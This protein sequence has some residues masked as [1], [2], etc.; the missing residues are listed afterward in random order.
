[1][2]I[3]VLTSTYSRWEGD[4]EPRFVDNLC[5]H[6]GAEHE[7]QVLAPHAPGARLHEV[8]D[9]IPVHRFRYAP[10]SLQTLAY[11]GGILPNLREQPLRF[12]LVPLFIAAQTRAILR[13]ARAHQFDVIHAHWIIPQGF[14]AALARLAGLRVPVVLTSHG[15][16][17][18]AL[19]GRLLTALKRW[20]TRRCQGLSVVSSA[21]RQQAADLGL[22]P[23][24][25][26]HNIPMGVDTAGEF[27]PPDTADERQGIVYVGR[28]VDKK[29]IEYL[30]EAMPAVLAALPMVRLTIV[31][32]GPL[33]QPLRA[34]CKALGVDAAVDFTGAIANT[35]VPGYLQRAAVTVFPSIVTD[36]GDQEGTPVAIME[37][38][39]CGCAAVVSDYPGAR[40]IIIDGQTG[41][42]VP[43]K[44]PQ[45]LA[46]ALLKL[47]GDPGLCRELGASGRRHVQTNYDWR[48][49]SNRFIEVFHGLI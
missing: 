42:L 22:M 43:Q 36:S 14:S 13:L 34:R 4:T 5:G 46:E 47:C 27:A 3:L 48:V 33:G 12:L 40:D 19:Q 2:K 28:L 41:V 38:L 24:E 11:G 8:L 45:A 39:A 26:I 18:F 16:D 6:L 25:R 44:S 17:L 35:A 32:D 31:G 23:L 20:I 10:E 7:V 37:A 29:G 9:G 49:I 30:I 15:G 21:M 1:V